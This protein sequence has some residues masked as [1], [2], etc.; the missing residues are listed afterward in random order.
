[1]PCIFSHQILATINPNSGS[2]GIPLSKKNVTKISRNSP[3]QK[4][5]YSAKAGTHRLHQA[6]NPMP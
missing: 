5:K 2:S 6:R 1:M 4:A 3:L